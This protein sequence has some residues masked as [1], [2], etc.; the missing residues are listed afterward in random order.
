MFERSQALVAADRLGENAELLREAIRRFPDDPTVLLNGGAATLAVDSIDE[1]KGYVRRA[2]ELAWDDP[3]R[4]TWAAS[5]MLN[6]SE[7]NEAKE[8][9]VRA[10]ETAPDDFELTGA[11]SFV[12]GR[13]ALAF[14]QQ[15]DAEQALRGA[16]DL[17]PSA[18]GRAELLAQ[19]LER[20]NRPTE[21]LE[22]LSEA[23]RHRPEAEDLTRM[24]DRI[25][26]NFQGN[27]TGTE[28][29]GALRS[30]RAGQGSVYE[31]RDALH[32]ADV[33]LPH[34]GAQGDSE[35]T[36]M[37]VPDEDGETIPLFSSEE[38][39]TAAM[40]GGQAHLQVPFTALVSGWPEGVDAVVDPGSEW[41]LRL[42]AH[43]LVRSH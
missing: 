43:T 4:L 31:V 34:P 5:L 17:E 38:T 11:L 12:L 7:F 41:A 13:V 33:F 15:Q 27:A 28:L 9:A 22:V 14:D 2:A 1:A 16:F 25:L 23:L 37:T 19:V 21:A 3:G 30:L 35:V 18:P 24:R 20:T 26:G 39:M 6:L 8:W 40:G 32:G 36:L 10:A 42:P 29:Q